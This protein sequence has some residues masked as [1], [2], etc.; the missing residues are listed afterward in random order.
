MPDPRK[1]PTPRSPKRTAGPVPLARPAATATSAH[2][3]TP[4]KAVKPVSK[5]TSANKTTPATAKP[6]R[7]GV[8]LVAVPRPAR[9]AVPAKQPAA[10]AL[11]PTGTVVPPVPVPAR[12]PLAAAH[13]RAPF[14]RM[15]V[16]VGDE[17]IVEVRRA[18]RFTLAA[19]AGWRA[20]VGKVVPELPA[21][22]F[23]LDG[24]EI[25]AS[26]GAAFDLADVLLANQHK[27]VRQ[28]AN[29]VPWA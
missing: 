27:F 22:P 15:F 29:L 9:R 20:V 7:E 2:I 12:T 10:E 16:L 1:S 3:A 25:A 8:S 4:K 18:Q 13:E 11:R 14:E 21:L 17:V 19:M 26:L 24:A 6:R 5:A 28:L 23:L